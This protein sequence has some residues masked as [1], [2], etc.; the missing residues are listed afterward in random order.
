MALDHQRS[1]MTFE[2]V[3]CW[4]AGLKSHLEIEVPYWENFLKNNRRMFNADESGFPLSVTNGKV[5]VEKKVSDTCIRCA[6]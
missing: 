4:F 1:L 5:L 2:M 6:K 3:K